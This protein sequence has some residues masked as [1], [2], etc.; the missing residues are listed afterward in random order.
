MPTL[1]A[2]PNIHD[3]VAPLLS[4]P[5]AEYNCWKVAQVLYKAGWNLDLASDP[6]LLNSAFD[7]VWWFQGDPR[8]PLSLVQPW[9][10][11]LLSIKGL[12]G[13]HCGV[14]L[15]DRLMVHTRKKAGVVKEPMHRWQ[16]RLW[17]IIRLK[18]LC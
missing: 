2:W 10:C 16:A 6:R 11:L 12:V 3:L 8:P 9:D 1:T 4:L 15:D 13:D 14:V 18:E 7:Q 17:Q 5:Y